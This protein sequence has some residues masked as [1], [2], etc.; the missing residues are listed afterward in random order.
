MWFVD[1]QVDSEQRPHKVS[2]YVDKGAAEE[3]IKTLT[4]RIKEREVS[5]PYRTYAFQVV[6]CKVTRQVHNA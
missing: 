6:L 3:I 5:C 2:F 4:E 1:C